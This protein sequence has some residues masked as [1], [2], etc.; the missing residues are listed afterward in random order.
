MPIN[1]SKV[2]TYARQLA[3]QGAAYVS[4]TGSGLMT[5]SGTIVKPTITYNNGGT[6]TI[7]S[8]GSYRFYHTQ[9]YFG[10]ITEHTIAGTT[11]NIPDQI[12]SYIA[13][14]YNSGTPQYSVTTDLSTVN[15]S[16]NVVVYTCSRVGDTNIDFLDW[17]EPSLGLSNKILRRDM[18]CRRF[19]RV[20]GLNLGEDV[21]RKIII[22][23]GAVWQGS[24]RNTRIQVDS[25][26]NNCILVTTNETGWDNVSITAYNNSQYD[27]GTGFSTLTDGNY[28]VNWIY[29]GMGINAESIIVFLGTGDYTLDQAKASQPPNVPLSITTNTMLIGKIIVLKGSTTATQIDSAF[30]TLFAPSSVL[31]FAYNEW[32]IYTPILGAYTGGTAPT[33]GAGSIVTGL[34]KV[35][36]KSLKCKV[37]ICQ[38]DIAGNAGSG[39]YTIS[40]PD[41]YTINTSLMPLATSDLTNQPQS[42]AAVLTKIPCGFGFVNSGG[43][44]NGV[45]QVCP[46]TTTTIAMLG[47]VGSGAKFIGSLWYQTSIVYQQYSIEFEVAIN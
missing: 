40:I 38:Q 16:N 29:R 11:L 20:T 34:Y 10:E 9:N 43:G 15:F 19:E 47:G 21:G 23:S 24:Y 18:E 3:S 39:H 27:T 30:Q 17:D 35:I 2:D 32:K 44:T 22:S 31:P 45:I 5:S 7:G 42:S 33:L 46:A 26:A 25:I 4:P 37:T 28:A 1:N 41:G 12:T 36:G 14:D 6:V 8:T 13:A